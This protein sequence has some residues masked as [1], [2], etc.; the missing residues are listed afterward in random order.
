[1]FLVNT[2]TLGLAERIKIFNNEWRSKNS[3]CDYF[4]VY[5]FNLTKWKS[6]DASEMRVWCNST[7]SHPKKFLAGYVKHSN[8]I[9][10]VVE[11]EYE[12]IY[13]GNMSQLIAQY[14]QNNTEI[15]NSTNITASESSAGS[16]ETVLPVVL[17]DAATE[18]NSTVGEALLEKPPVAFQLMEENYVARDDVYS[19]TEDQTSYY[20]ND[21]MSG[22]EYTEGQSELSFD[23]KSSSDTSGILNPTTTTNNVPITTTTP[24]STVKQDYTV[25]RY[26]KRPKACTNFFLD[27][28]DFL[29]CKSSSASSLSVVGIFYSSF[30]LVLII[31]LLF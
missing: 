12:L 17:S 29:P 26:R 19:R 20:N 28:R 8:L 9:M 7:N 10:L 18:T 4:G 25:N 1:M 30:W 3:H 21:L 14:T 24:A 15:D 2:Q 16:N 13:C 22:S 23:Y 27:E 5:S 31:C 6:L 11:D